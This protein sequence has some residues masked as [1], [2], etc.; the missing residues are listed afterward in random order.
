LLD[1]SDSSGRAHAREGGKVVT[2]G[3]NAGGEEETR[4]LPG[5]LLGEEVDLRKGGREGW[6]RR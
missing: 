2:S 4:G 1:K 6:V 5:V 3:Q